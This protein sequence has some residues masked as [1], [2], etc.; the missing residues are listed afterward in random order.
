MIQQKLKLNTRNGFL[1][2]LQHELTVAREQLNFAT[3]VFIITHGK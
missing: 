1:S 3:R 2:A